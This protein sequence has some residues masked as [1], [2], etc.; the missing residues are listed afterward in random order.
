MKNLAKMYCYLI[1]FY[2]T[3]MDMSENLKKIDNYIYITLIGM[4]TIMHIFKITLNQT[5]NLDISLQYSKD[6]CFLF[7]EYI[8]QM[9]QT[10]SLHNLNNIDAITFV[11]KKIN[12]EINKSS[13]IR[14]SSVTASNSSIPKNDNKTIH[15]FNKYS[16]IITKTLFYFFEEIDINETGNRLDETHSRC[17]EEKW[18]SIPLENTLS[19]AQFIEICRTHLLHFLSLIH[20]TESEYI[21]PDI[22]Y[23]F[24]HIHF[25]Q[26]KLKFNYMDYLVYLQE[27][28][29]I[30]QRMKKN[31]TLPSEVKLYNTYMEIYNNNENMD[32]LRDYIENHKIQNI[33][34][35]FFV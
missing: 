12:D 2:L 9:N 4:E 29:K 16:H 32:K 6:A 35:L 34:K 24:K 28:Y 13:C 8:E 15:L 14:D 18:M 22:S 23:I 3:N 17:N 21:D 26:K 27:V 7:S 25:T 1:E 19:I 11:F 33:A 30:I 10:N 31:N 20:Y 5:K